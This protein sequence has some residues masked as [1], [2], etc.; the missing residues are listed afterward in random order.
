MH[1]GK[2]TTTLE[3]PQSS[4]FKEIPAVDPGTSQYLYEPD[5]GVHTMLSNRLLFHGPLIQ[6]QFLVY[7]P[8]RSTLLQQRFLLPYIPQGDESNTLRTVN[9]KWWCRYIATVTVFTNLRDE[10]MASLRHS[11]GYGEVP[12]I[13]LCYV[14]IL[15]DGRF[16]Q[17]HWWHWWWLSRLSLEL[18][19]E[20]LMGECMPYFD[21]DWST[22]WLRMLTVLNMECLVTNK[23]RTSVG[24]HC[25]SEPH[26]S[27]LCLMPPY[28]VPTARW[29]KGTAF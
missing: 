18:S 14:S 23:K 3:K 10:L 6:S 15:I 5:S 26:V 13:W 22:K 11:C 21:V 2:F 4:L 8:T 25:K 16:T 27:T 29:N 12:E 19:F 24:K 28:Q 17:V 1:A 9:T 20:F 7:H